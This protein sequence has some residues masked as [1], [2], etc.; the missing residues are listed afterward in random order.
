MID[1]I[2]DNTNTIKTLNVNWLQNLERKGKISKFDLEMAI[3]IIS[4]MP[5]VK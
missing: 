4:K 5:L 3:D 2:R 1:E